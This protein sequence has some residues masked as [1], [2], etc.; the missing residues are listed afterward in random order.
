VKRRF[1]L[2]GSLAQRLLLVLVATL[3]MVAIG[4][5][6]GGAVLIERVVEQSFDK[7]LGAS[8]RAIADTIAPEHGDVTLE[9]PPSA[10]EMLEDP[11]RDNVYYSV[12]QAQRLLTGYAELPA[13]SAAAIQPGQTVF[14]Y[15]TF[16][17]QDVRI[18]AEARRVPHMPDLVVVEVAQTLGERRAL[19]WM[20]LAGLIILE[21][22]FVGFAA[23]LV[24]PALSWSLRP[25]NRLRQ[26]IDARPADHA[27]F[28]PLDLRYTP[29]EVAGLVAGFNGL[30]KRL[31]DAV[32]GMRQFT[33]DASHQMRTPLAILKTHVAV[34]KSQVDSGSAGAK[35]LTDVQNAVTR[36]E[37]LLTR[38]IT[39]ARADEAVGGGIKR[40]AVD[41]RAVV[42]HVVGD[43]LP[44]SVQRDITI[45]VNSEERA[46]WAWAEPLLA[47]EILSNLVD[48][49]I[50]YNRPGGHIWISIVEREGRAGVSVEDDGPGVPLEEQER[51]QER[52]YRLPRDQAQQGSGL[53]L[54][55]VKTLA[56][57][58]RARVTL[59]SRS[60]G[61]GLRVSIEFDSYRSGTPN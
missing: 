50:R 59:E 23:L 26:E 56:E 13:I 60:E 38:L 21:V 18:A 10:L 28:S 30:L 39:L 42:A 14:R 46:V 61:Q 9:I 43:L 31:A 40:A 53:G 3:T 52:F 48:N 16:R 17:A 11:Q 29:H 2:D 47:A 19:A 57:A 44:Q 4:L 22:S 25:V 24:W 51:V 34:L 20:M 15:A 7:L 49:A 55:I 35:S 33:S 1:Q 45:D 8:V 36:L 5:G 54:S 32:A 12:R 27:N 6:A 37:L 58:L 41:L